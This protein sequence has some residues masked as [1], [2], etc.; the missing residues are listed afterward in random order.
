MKTPKKIYCTLV[1]VIIFII[2]FITAHDDNLPSGTHVMPDGNNVK[3][4]EMASQTSRLD[5]P[6]IVTLIVAFIF[7][8]GLVW[9][10]FKKRK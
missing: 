2:S 6:T 10:Y 3:N 4:S 9:I 8:G 1:I 7:I 5:R